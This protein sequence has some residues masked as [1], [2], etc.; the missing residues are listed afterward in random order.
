M[1][2]SNGFE[3]QQQQKQDGN[4]GPNS[5]PE[6]KNNLAPRGRSRGPLS[7][8]NLSQLDSRNNMGSYSRQKEPPRPPPPRAEGKKR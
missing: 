7:D 4:S 1:N 5:L 2:N 8:A 3:E 6:D